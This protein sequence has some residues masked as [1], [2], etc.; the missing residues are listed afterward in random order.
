M[1]REGQIPET[2][3][4][5]HSER[6]RPREEGIKGDSKV[7][8]LEGQVIGTL[9]RPSR[10]ERVSKSQDRKGK[11]NTNHIHKAMCARHGQ[12]V[13]KPERSLLSSEPERQL[14][15]LFLTQGISINSL[16]T[17]SFL[18]QQLGRSLRLENG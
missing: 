1:A 15:L 17:S 2:E 16:L 3:L 6:G 14:H 9:G 7:E 8:C 13:P 12:P 4:P 18:S 11:E 5:V 10:R